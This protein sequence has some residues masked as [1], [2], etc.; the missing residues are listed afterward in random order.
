MTTIDFPLKPGYECKHAA[1]GE[2]DP[3]GRGFLPQS[4]S[5]ALLDQIIFL[6]T[7]DTEEMSVVDGALHLVTRYT[8]I[9]T[10]AV[11]RS[12]RVITWEMERSKDRRSAVN[13]YT[14]DV[15]ERQRNESQSSF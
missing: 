13:L 5:R 2:S 11:D 8:G 10:K 6:D 14:I 7:Y 4:F 1:S 3:D 15:Q 12:S 9:A